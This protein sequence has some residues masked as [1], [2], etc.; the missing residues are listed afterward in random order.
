MQNRLGLRLFLLVIV[1]SAVLA[2]GSTAFQLY[3]E[4]RRDAQAIDA[5]LDQVR[6]SA[7]DSLAASLWYFNDQQLRLQLAGLLRTRDVQF[8][9]VRPSDGEPM[10]VGKRPAGAQISRDYPLRHGKDQRALGTLT[11]V[12]GL[13][14]LYVRLLDQARVIALG[15]LAKALL[16]AGLLMVVVRHW[17]TRRLDRMAAYARTLSLDRLGQPLRLEDRRPGRAPDE[18]DE[19]AAALNEMSGALALELERRSAIDAERARLVDAFEHHR[20]LMQSII[21]NTSAIIFVRDLESRLL[22][23]NR[24]YDELFG[25]GRELIGR[26]VHELFPDRAAMLQVS[27]Q[28]VVAADESVEYEMPVDVDGDERTYLTVKFPLRGSS[29]A[30]FGIA[31]IATDITERKRDDARIRFLAHHDALTG[32]PNRTL[33]CDRIEQSISQAR[34]NDAQVALLF[35][36]LDHFKNINDSLGH[37]A[38]DRLLVAVA[39]RLQH[40][41]REG[42][43]VARLGGDEFVV[44]LPAL[45]DSADIIAIGHKLLRALRAP[46]QIGADAL[47][48]TGSIG[49]AVYPDDGTDAEALMRAADA[50]M[51]HAKEQGRDNFKFYTASLNDA[52]QRRLQI[53]TRLHQGLEL[54][55]FAMHYQPQVDLESGRIYGAEALIRWRMGDGTVVAPNEFIRIA[56]ETGFIVPLGDWILETACRD[57]VAWRACGRPEL[58]VAVNLSP[59]Q[60][61]RAGFVEH[62]AAVLAQTGL[63]AEALE[64]EITEGVL[65]TRS[66]ETLALLGRLAAMGIRL[67][68]DDFG[69][70][71]S[72]LAYLQRFPVKVVKID[73]AFVA[74]IG[75]DAGD[76]AIVTAI[77]AMAQGLRLQVVAEGVETDAQAAFL[78]SRGAFAVQGWLFSP[79]VP[80][81]QFAALLEQ[82]PWTAARADAAVDAG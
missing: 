22:L 51:Y 69:T 50:A 39:E 72:S 66:D 79:A 3:R 59:R 8:V 43:T 20:F 65:L 48:M 73:R 40:C 35:V 61:L 62:V 10:A 78:K 47:H 68:I 74:A 21:D 26:T 70:G 41:L 36:D 4:Y 32:L 56:E 52:A 38:G 1:A 17:V 13:D 55:E 27:D 57:A 30:V 12:V 19:V 28:R 76:T 14:A 23:A 16:L 34:R 53:A 42:D 5:Q 2:L 29:G 49:I 11:V 18:L 6:L 24:R 71:Y 80:A 9:E 77:I 81:A 33:L 31:C 7:L 15:E 64:L 63:P 60:L 46:F 82:P 45:H 37:G 25:Q 58:S 75:D 67:A 54:G 44:A